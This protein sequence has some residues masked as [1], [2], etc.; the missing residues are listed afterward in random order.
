MEWEEKTRGGVRTN[1]VTSKTVPKMLSFTKSAIRWSGASSLLLDSCERVGSVEK[2]DGNA[3]RS[4]SSGLRRVGV[5]LG[6]VAG[7]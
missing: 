6:V 4:S 5:A 3:R 1:V 7:I 2:E